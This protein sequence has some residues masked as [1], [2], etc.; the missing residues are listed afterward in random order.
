MCVFMV[1]ATTYRLYAKFMDPLIVGVY[2]CM[3]YV[4]MYVYDKR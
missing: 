3:Y 4:C 1:Y 2:V